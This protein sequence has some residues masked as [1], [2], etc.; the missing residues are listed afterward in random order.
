MF[1]SW[2]IHSAYRQLLGWFV[3]K[4]GARTTRLSTRMAMEWTP[5]QPPLR[6]GDS[7]IADAFMDGLQARPGDSPA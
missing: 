7:V 2:R 6:P 4:T 5:Y 3:A 1:W